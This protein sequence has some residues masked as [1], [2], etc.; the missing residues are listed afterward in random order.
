MRCLNNYSFICSKKY[1]VEQFLYFQAQA[2]PYFDS[3]IDA[4]FVQIT[5]EWQKYIAHVISYPGYIFF[6]VWT[7][8]FK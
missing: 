2:N 7:I 8:S 4:F 5:W 6:N 1:E 3:L